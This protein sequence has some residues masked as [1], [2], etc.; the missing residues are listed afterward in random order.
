MGVIEV[1]LKAVPSS[2]LDRGVSTLLQLQTRFTD[3]KREGTISSLVPE[4]SGFAG[5]VFGLLAS[6]VWIEPKGMIDGNENAARFARAT[7]HLE[8]GDLAKAVAEVEQCDACV[9]EVA[10]DWLLD[11]RGR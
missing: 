3:V 10:S 9:Q 1:A 11:A 7:C 5:H 6:K 8:V 4:G 2:V